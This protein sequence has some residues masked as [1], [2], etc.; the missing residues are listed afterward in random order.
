[1]QTT[2]NIS[3][4]DYFVKTQ[5]IST[6]FIYIYIYIIYHM[7]NLLFLAE[8]YSFQKIYSIYFL[9]PNLDSLH[10]KSPQIAWTFLSE[11]FR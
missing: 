8:K 4:Y 5:K 6:K 1:M 10:Q 11:T 9:S 2:V 7:N 3:F